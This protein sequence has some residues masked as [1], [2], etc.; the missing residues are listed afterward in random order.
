MGRLAGI[1]ALI[2]GAASG[3]GRETAR[4]FVAE[5]AQVVLVDRDKAKLDAVGSELGARTIVIDLGQK[6]VAEPV[7]AEA[8]EALGG[9]DVLV[10][11]AGILVRQPFET[12]DEDL[13]QQLFDVNLRGLAMMC[14]AALPSLQ[15]SDQPAIVNIASFSALRP[16][17]GTS[18]YAA[19]KAGVLMF[20]RCLAEEIAPV[21]VNVI[22][23][24]I[25]DSGMTEDFMS[26]PETR[27][28]I[29]AMNALN[30]VGQPADIAAACVYLASPEARY[31]N[32]TQLV[33]DGGSAYM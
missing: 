1:K 28:E 32:G 22:C 29:A 26:D 3:I 9:L 27:K 2:T 33:V 24:G 15:A 23:P 12:I 17:P 5:G 19:T 25:V 13:W 10:N 18:A 4:Q 21:R 30:S 7:L 6:G 20:S 8:V 14:R 31:V 11:A 16:T